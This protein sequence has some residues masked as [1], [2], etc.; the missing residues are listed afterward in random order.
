MRRS[1][2]GSFILWISLTILTLL[3][4]WWM[5]VVSM[6]PRVKLYSKSF[7]IDDL[8]WDNFLAVLNSSTFLQYL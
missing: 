1:G 5:L 2:L 6:R 4:V 3:P 7:L 8:Y